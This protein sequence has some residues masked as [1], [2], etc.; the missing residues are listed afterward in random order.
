MRKYV[1]HG[2]MVTAFLAGVLGYS[3]SRQLD[4]FRSPDKNGVNVFEAPKDTV[5][6]FDGVKVR[7]GGSSTLQFQALDHENSG[8]V[9]L[10]EIGDNFN[11]A[12]ANLDLD[13]ALAKGVRMHLRTY[14]S[15]RHHPEPYVKG[16]Y[17]QVDNLDFISPGFLEEAMKYLTIKVGHMENNYGDTHFRRSDNSQ[18]MHNPFV[19]NLI[20]DAFTTEVGGEVYYRNNGFIGMFGLSNG[21]LNQAVNNPGTTGVSILAKLG[22]DKQLS[23]DLRFRLTGSMYSTSK[24]ARVYLYSADRAGSR[25][26][27]VM[28]DVDAS[29]TSNFRSGRY[30]PGF[31]NEITA[32][33][34]NPF[35]K[36]KG[37]E[38]FGTFETASGKTDAETDD[39]NA[40]QLAGELIYRFGNNENFYL[41][42]RYN[43]VTSDDPSGS[44][45]TIDR[46]QLGGGV[47]L[48]KNILTKIEY[49][50]QQYDGYDPTSIF[51]EGQF[52]GVLLEAVISF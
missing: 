27:L 37:L 2:L 7:V 4:N 18:A 22:Y 32:F 48:T 43:T 23:D 31:N 44:E 19:G 3:Q 45:V 28:E 49:V 24:S 34:I 26:Y 40:T 6:T 41:G 20:M 52:N 10:I 12:T 29:A 9:E 11:L 15:S 5:S 25:Y 13:V 39:R 35:V 46:F 36:W 30:N 38:F 1:K 8:A 47:F 51:N 16:G 21:K 17:F 33:M 42:T 50:N 14:L